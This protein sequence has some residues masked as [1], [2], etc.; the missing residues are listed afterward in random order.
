MIMHSLGDSNSSRVLPGGPLEVAAGQTA[1]ADG[2][3]SVVVA[4]SATYTRRQE[5]EADRT[6]ADLMDR[7]RFAHAAAGMFAGMFE[8]VVGLVFRD[9]AERLNRNG[10]GGLVEERPPDGRH[11]QRLTLWISLEAPVAVPPR[12]DRNPYIQFEVDVPWR[13][14]TVWEGDIWHKLGASRCTRPFTLDEVTTESVAAGAVSV[15]RR[16]VS[17]GDPPVEVA[18]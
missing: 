16:T 1:P 6:R 9:V 2:G 10:G 3:L 13:H 11:G 18:Q 8:R 15:L 14:I 4:L 5:D 7:Q 12:V 17:R